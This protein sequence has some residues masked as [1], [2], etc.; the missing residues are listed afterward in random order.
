V[1]LLTEQ[2]AVP[3]LLL[4]FY[5]IRKLTYTQMFEAKQ[6]RYFLLFINKPEL[7]TQ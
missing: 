3:I 1:L 6:A 7:K 5:Y 2:K 4:I